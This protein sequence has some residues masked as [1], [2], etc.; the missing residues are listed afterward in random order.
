MINPV[1]SSA[2]TL[3]L[4]IVLIV[5]AIVAWALLT[6]TK[7]SLRSYDGPFDEDIQDL[8]NSRFGHE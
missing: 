1:I 6:N 3:A 7:E 5:W 8:K 2:M 4:I